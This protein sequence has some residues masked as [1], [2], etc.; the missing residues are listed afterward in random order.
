ML[1]NLH[2]FINIAFLIVIFY[3]ITRIKMV[4]K[5]K[6][7][8]ILRGKQHFRPVT[9]G[10]CFLMPVVDKLVVYDVLQQLRVYDTC[11]KVD[12]HTCFSIELVMQ[13]SIIDESVFYINH[14]DQFMKESVLEI[15]RQYIRTFG[16]KGI[17]QQK[18]ALEAR[19]KGKVL[20]MMVQWGIEL[21]SLHLM[22]IKECK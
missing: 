7:G 6:I 13:Y 3:M 8:M 11:M 1:E 20:E 16:S 9:P 4:P 15:I 10:I 18:I 21:S 22:T 5:N 17:Q 19:I 12:D 2:I 14:M